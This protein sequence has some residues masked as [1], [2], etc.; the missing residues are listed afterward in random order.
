MCAHSVFFSFFPHSGLS[1]GLAG[2]HN[3]CNPAYEAPGFK[4]ARPLGIIHTKKNKKK[5]IGRHARPRRALATALLH[6]G[7]DT[8]KTG[9]SA[10]KRAGAK[11]DPVRRRSN[12]AWMEGQAGMR[13]RAKTRSGAGG[14]TPQTAHQAGT[15][16]Q[17][18]NTATSCAKGTDG[19]GQLQGRAGTGQHKPWQQQR[20]YDWL[21]IQIQV[22]MEGSPT[23]RN[24]SHS[25]SHTM[26]PFHW[27]FFGFMRIVLLNERVISTRCL[28]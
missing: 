11:S 27:L 13:K 17:D 25:H 12:H 15:L 8:C 7:A 18:P 24:H 5:Q 3:S 23:V 6:T 22:A 20:G 28:L 4:S 2:R 14:C 16:R 10:G 19:P 9:S 21:E 1:R 26:F